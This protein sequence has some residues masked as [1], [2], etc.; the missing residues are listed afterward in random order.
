MKQLLKYAA[1][2]IL[3]LITGCNND[4]TSEKE[5]AVTEIPE[6]P[7]ALDLYTVEIDSLVSQLSR[8][9]KIEQLF[10]IDMNSTLID[11]SKV[12]PKIAG[13]RL[14]NDLDQLEKLISKLDSNESGSVHFYSNSLFAP[15]EIAHCKMDWQRENLLYIKDTNF[16]HQFYQTLTHSLTDLTTTFLFLDTNHLVFD[17]MNSV[18][19][20]AI[21]DSLY[22]HHILTSTSIHKDSLI[23]KN[24]IYITWEDSTN[25]KTQTKLRYNITSKLDID[26]TERILEQVVIG[27][28]DAL[29]LTIRSKEELIAFNQLIAELS[30][31]KAVD[32]ELLDYKVRKIIALKKWMIHNETQKRFTKINFEKKHLI[33]IRALN[34]QGYYKSI[35]AIKTNNL[36]LVDWPKENWTFINIGKKNYKTFRNNIQLYGAIGVKHL[37]E[38][39]HLNLGDLAN[40]SPLI[41]LLN[42]YQLD[43]TSSARLQTE[44]NTTSATCIVV[45]VGQPTN[46]EYLK[47]LKNIIYSPNS[48]DQHLAMLGQAVMGGNPITGVLNDSLFQYR[49]TTKT[50]LSYSIP[51]EVGI[52]SDSLKKIDK[53]ANGAVWGGVTPGC[54]VFAAKD[55]KVIYNKAYGYLTYDKKKPITTKTVYDIASVTK[56]AATTLCGMKMYEDSLYQLNDSLRKH[57]PD[58]L[59]KYLGHP[60]R[61]SNITFQRLFTHTSGLPSGLPIYKFIAYVDS[62][63]GKFDRYYCDETSG[64]YCVEV[65][66]N[67]YLDSSYLDSMWIDMNRIWTGEKKYKYS[68]ANMNVLYQIFRSKLDKNQTYDRYISATFY[69]RLHLSH[70]TFLP[71]D[72][73]DTNTVH[74]APTEFDTYWRYQLLK[75]NVH[76]PNAA[77]YGGV[78]GNAGVFS[79][80]NELGVIAQLLMNGGTYGG[81]RILNTNTINRFTKH[82]TG[83]HRG[84]GFDKPTSGSGS[85]VAYDCPYTSYGHTGFTGICTW[86]DTEND[87]TFVF[88]SNRVHPDPGNK[89]II[90]QG[91]RRNI[92]QVFY[93]QLYY[94]GI[95]KNK[96]TD[97][98]PVTKLL[99]SDSTVI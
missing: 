72:Y 98:V 66:K 50:R 21:K 31:H 95:Y 43:S 92:H 53:I 63:I 93:D 46:L 5:Y 57:L 48:S 32:S 12:L 89:K 42:E 47:G 74:I 19:T 36:P 69:D 51:E 40:S 44:I 84:L 1:L 71:N 8:K 86:N 2:F 99:K 11:A 33:D 76:D 81:S 88:V 4:A 7:K 67:F 52:L 49:T 26:Q 39:K 64:Y 59:T 13:Y 55:G 16:T 68:D 78:A 87:L 20:N 80:A 35:V 17:A 73:L 29:K 96:E 54:Q 24:L 79:T 62:I 65:A 82:Q 94:R 60:S 34:Y 41:I 56:V 85:Y 77:L 28:F 23:N 27:N 70:T 22:A 18:L 9:E 45:S 97:N 75:G 90:F 25:T 83:S 58:S 30:V 37:Q 14:P 38:I 15:F 6:P 61:L 91:V 10:W 3:F